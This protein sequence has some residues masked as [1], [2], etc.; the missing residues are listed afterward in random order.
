ME[1][2]NKKIVRMV[3]ALASLTVLESFNE[4]KTTNKIKPKADA[5]T[6]AVKINNP[7]LTNRLGE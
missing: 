7:I 2:N 4:I 6:N 3:V 5:I 1:N